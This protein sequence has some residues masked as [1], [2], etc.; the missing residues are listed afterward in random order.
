MNRPA[1]GLA[2]LCGLL[3]LACPGDGSDGPAP[4][5]RFFSTPDCRVIAGGFPS[6]LTRLPARDDALAVV[7]FAPPA[8]LAADLDFEPPRLLAPA[9]VPPWPELAS[10]RCGGLRVDSDG[11]G[12]PDPD[13]S[14]ELGFQCQS[15]APGAVAPFGADRV[16][17]TTSSYE[18]VLVVEPI[19]GELRVVA[20]DP[21]AAG[22]GFAPADWPF[23]PAAGVLPFQTGFSTR[24]CVYD[25]AAVDSNG[26]AI[27]ANRLCDAG[28]DGF[29]TTFTS[30]VAVAADRI[31]V[32]TSNLIRATD[33]RFA[34]GTVL[35]FDVDAGA[36]PPR[37]G[38][39][40]TRAI[41]RTTGYNPT[42][43]TPWTT[44][45]GRELILV[46]VTGAIAQGTGPGLVRSAS[47]IDVI[48]ATTLDVIATI[49]LGLAGLGFD[50]LAIDPT[51]RLGLIGAAVGRAL[52]GVDLAA[53]DDPSLGTG[54]Q[55]LPIVL[56]GMTPGFPDARVYDADRPFVLPKRSDGPLD[57]VCTTQT[58][59]DIQDQGR[60]AAAIDFCDGTITRLDLSLPGGRTTPLDP[61]ALLR[62]DRSIDVVAP[63]VPTATTR[64]R[65]PAD[66]RIRSGTP[67]VD[68][69]GADVHFTAGL[70]TGA[71]CGVRID[72]S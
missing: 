70:P 34:P 37:V 44:P 14:D 62:V 43:L 32:A 19:S 12:R 2:L 68:F 39:H 46:G 59:V 25:A 50:G 13:R 67:G 22:P 11:D 23:W 30:D 65:A 72:A 63:L 16:L 71:L 36:T 31:F 52:Y 49:P 15:P 7:Q 40:P 64:L 51:D 33:A 35:V 6:G 60:F 5:L 47:A 69:D 21:P 45:S 41:L 3:Q 53:L 27:G 48:D 4:I 57:G 10:P 58:A 17:L 38:P 29:V 66:I 55:T 8:V 28:R 18:Q 61:D 9:P 26:A 1:L 42:S 20:L 24:A 56:D 54:P